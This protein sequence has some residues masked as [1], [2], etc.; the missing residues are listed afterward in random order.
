[1][2]QATAILAAWGDVRRCDWLEGSPQ[3]PEQEPTLP[4]SRAFGVNG[5]GAGFS[6]AVDMV[7]L[8]GLEVDK[9]IRTS[10]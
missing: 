2:D 6:E 10:V 9:Y 5:V 4:R 8:E 3:I 7:E 1:M